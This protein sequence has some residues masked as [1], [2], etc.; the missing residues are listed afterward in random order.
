MPDRYRGE[1]T[2]DI[3]W[4]RQALHLA[5]DSVGL[6]SP[7]PQVGCVL[8]RDGNVV[9]RGA[10]LYDEHDHAEVAALKAA[11]AQA[12]G[13]TA[14]VTLEPCSHTGRTG[15]CA[16]ALIQAGVARVVAATGDPN[17]L[18]HGRGF[19]MLRDAGIEVTQGVLA[20][21]ARALNDGFA[22]W[23]RS[24]LPCVT[25]K[26]GVSLDGRIAPSSS[27]GPPG[28]VTYLTGAR[29]L[30]AVQKLRHAADAVLTGIGTVLHDNPLLTDRSGGA[31]RR[32]LLRVVLD[33]QLRLPMGSRLVQ[34]A[35]NDV[36]VYTAKTSDASHGSRLDALQA[37]GVQIQ[38]VQTVSTSAS[39]SATE[40][41]LDLHEVLHLLGTERQVLNVLAEGGS[42][43]NRAF[44]S[45]EQGSPHGSPLA[46]KL[47]LFYAPILLGEKGV[48][49][50]AGSLPLSLDPHRFT[51]TE[52]SPDFRMEACLRDPWRES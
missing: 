3:R 26:A 21:E 24:K 28:S 31:R 7:N 8:V 39:A 29:S 10:H 13:A 23:I 34:S 40:G 9:G 22:K 5:E 44:L 49:L 16:G 51:V 41:R 46:D 11:G 36:L 37:A 30:L 6:A 35:N 25:L 14:Y 52:S 38:T 50:I 18:V 48:P 17:P 27:S 1:D 12:Q 4:M 32:P 2:P 47:C 33:S 42:R 19:A 20:D 43:L 15:P 45:T